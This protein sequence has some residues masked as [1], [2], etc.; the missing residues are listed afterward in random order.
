MCVSED[1]VTGLYRCRED[2]VYEEKG[3]VSEWKERLSVCV[4]ER[5]VGVWREEHGYVLVWSDRV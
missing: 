5:W 3:G 2:V 4:Y 1:G